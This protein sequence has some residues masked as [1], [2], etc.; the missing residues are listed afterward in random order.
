M[1]NLAYVRVSTL[2]QNNERQIN[3]IK[4]RADI[5]VDG[6]FIEKVSGKNTDRVQLDALKK[7]CRKGD[8]I[9]IDAFSRLARSTKDLLELIEYFKSKGAEIISLKENLDTSTPNGK[10]MLTIIAAISEFEREQLLERQAEGIAIAKANGKYEG[11]KRIEI[12][13]ELRELYSQWKKRKITKQEI[14]NITGI[15]RT[16]LHRR[17]KE[18]DEQ[19]TTH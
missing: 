13:D 16:T 3:N 9:Y 6:W 17:F 1:T 10:L 7:H 18:M 15:S 8:V 11:R 14:V 2:E 5:D 19:L 12:T 4:S